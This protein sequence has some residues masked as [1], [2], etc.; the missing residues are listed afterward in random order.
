MLIKIGFIDIE[1]NRSPI[2]FNP[3][4]NRAIREPTDRNALTHSIQTTL[5]LQMAGSTLL[6]AAVLCATFVR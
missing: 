5:T 3:A 6:L 2:V 4:I 1:T